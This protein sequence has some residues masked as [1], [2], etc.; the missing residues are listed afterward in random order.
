MTRLVDRL[1]TR[2]G[3]DLILNRKVEDKENYG[4]NAAQE[5]PA[6]PSQDLLSGPERKIDNSS[7]E[8]KNLALQLNQV[9][10]ESNVQA[11]AAPQA[12]ISSPLLE[13][14]P[15]SERSDAF[16][17][18]HSESDNSARG[19]FNQVQNLKMSGKVSS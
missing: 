2:V 6:K 19:Q 12:A 3:P 9:R 13:Q 15:E 1:I 14:A 7:K 5:T 8:R 18:P 16:S 17:I 10:K 11:S 4:Q